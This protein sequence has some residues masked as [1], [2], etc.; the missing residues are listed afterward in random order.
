M[1]SGP[2]CARREIRKRAAPGPIGHMTVLDPGPVWSDY[3]RRFFTSEHR[4]RWSASL[5][6]L[7]RQAAGVMAAGPFAY[8]A[9]SAG[10]GS[11]ER[12]NREAFDRWRLCPG[13]LTASGTRDLSTEVLGRRLAAP[14]LAAPVGVQAILHPDAER[15]TASACAALGIPMIMSTMAS[16]SIEDVAAAAGDGP[17]WFQLY[18]PND[19]DVARSILDRARRS[20]FDV[21]VVTTD[22][23][24]LGWRPQ[25]LDSSYLPMLQGVGIEV[26]L[27]DPVFRAGLDVPPEVDPRA[28]VAAWDAQLG[29]APRSWADL[30]RLRSWWDGPIVIKGVLR[31][32]DARRAV[33]AGLDGVVVSNH[34]G[35]QVDGSVAALDALPEVVDEIGAE[36]TVLVDS[37][38]R[39]GADVVKALALGAQAVLLG[40]PYAYGL[41]LGGASGVE[42]V[43]RCLL[44]DLD[45]TLGLVGLD[46]VAD[47][48]L[49]LVR[50]APL[51]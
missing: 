44:A 29:C 22:T 49:G 7:E 33:D 21:L 42:H 39:G 20:G 38:V 30:A 48:D 13:T 34:G 1:R 37:G 51:A 50:R 31:A 24:S 16:T 35:R 36:A 17:R 28:A 4:P 47:V 14:V 3:T 45:L 8:V 15:A 23:M 26:F 32:G 10:I 25:V 9:G 46:R 2:D 41:A 40:R 27:S 6:E 12:A 19:D 18:W 11:T 5:L 43:L